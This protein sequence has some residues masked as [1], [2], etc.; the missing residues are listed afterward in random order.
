MDTFRYITYIINLV[1]IAIVSGA[2][3]EQFLFTILFFVKKKILPKTTKLHKIAVFIPARNESGV[4]KST[5]ET[6]LSSDYPKELF[7]VYVI[8]NN[9]TDN[10]AEVARNAGAY[11]Y[12]M[13]DSNPKHKNAAYPIKYFFE[14]IFKEGKEYD[15]YVRF[16]ADNSPASNY[17]SR[18]NDAYNAGYKLA[19]GFN[20][21]KNLTQNNTAAISGLWYIRDCRFACHARDAL[22]CGQMLIGPGM[23]FAHSIIAQ[24]GGWTA[25]TNSEDS[26]FMMNQLFK[27]YKAKYVCDAVVYEDQPSTVKDVF[28]RNIRMGHSLHK[29]FW[30]HGWKSLWYWIKSGFKFTYLDMFINFLFIPVALITCVWFPLY[31]GF[32][33]IYNIIYAVQGSQ[34]AIDFLVELAI[35]IAWVL[36]FL[37]ISFIAQAIL[38]VYLERDIV[39]VPVKKLL[40]PIF[41]F[42]L[43]MVIYEIGISIGCVSKPKW[44]QIK[45]NVID[46]SPSEEVSSNKDG[47]PINK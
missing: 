35:M 42:P 45:R 32:E 19:R 27:G 16:D 20:A 5:V 7:D 11:V 9:C 24:D 28:N 33:V 29:M 23:M 46:V 4:I 43:Y 13:E 12:E 39:K 36:G 40:K 14:Q 18:M 15:F 44:N 26:E 8:A 38:V 22:N 6:I 17:L 3:L 2:F 41:I 30:T 37:I 47:D 10:T 31:Y 25:L 1:I 21:S 34:V